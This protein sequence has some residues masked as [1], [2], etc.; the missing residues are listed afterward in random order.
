M[1]MSTKLKKKK[2]QNETKEIIAVKQ[3]IVGMFTFV[4]W[5]AQMFL[6]SYF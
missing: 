3:K 6:T 4:A 5:T 1:R 2:K